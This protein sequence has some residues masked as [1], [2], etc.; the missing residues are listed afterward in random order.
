M[1]IPRDVAG[2]D[3]VK[4]LKKFGYE[5]VRQNGSH[6]M[7]TSATKGEH[8]LVIPNHNPIKVGT[9][10]GILSKVAVHFQLSKDEVV[11]KLFG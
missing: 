6:I 11:K 9:L 10:N 8:Y 5:I 4:A 3:I 7:V 1:K 2:K